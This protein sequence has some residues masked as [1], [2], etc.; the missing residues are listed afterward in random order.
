MTETENWLAALGQALKGMPSF[1]GTPNALDLPAA[2][3]FWESHFGPIRGG[4]DPVAANKAHAAGRM[5]EFW[6]R[7]IAER[8]ASAVA[9][10]GRELERAAA[11]GTVAGRPVL[12][13][14][15]VPARCRGE[16][17]G[18]AAPVRV[19]KTEAGWCPDPAFLAEVPRTGWCV[20]FGPPPY[21]PWL[22]PQAAQENAARLN[23]SLAAADA[24]DEAVREQQAREQQQREQHRRQLAAR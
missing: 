11:A 8:L 12:R 24:R 5:A 1:P 6:G 9:D 15:E 23:E 18:T 2:A 17:I 21:C 20:V 4:V 3:E 16:F 14:D 13:W 19:A 10:I 7:Q 22:T